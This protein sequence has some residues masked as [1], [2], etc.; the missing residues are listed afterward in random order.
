MKKAKRKGK[1]IREEQLTGFCIIHQHTLLIYLLSCSLRTCRKSLVASSAVTLRVVR[2]KTRLWCARERTNE[3][4]NERGKRADKI[5]AKLKKHK[6]TI[7]NKSRKDKSV[8]VRVV[9]VVV[10]VVVRSRLF[11]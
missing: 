8:V 10:V 11:H 3:R 7:I 4:K 5:N 9:A 1:E 6:N 2:D